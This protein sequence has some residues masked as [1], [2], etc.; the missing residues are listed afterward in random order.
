MRIRINDFLKQIRTRIETRVQAI[1]QA[2][3]DEDGKSFGSSSV[4]WPAS[5]SHRRFTLLFS[6]L[7]RLEDGISDGESGEGCDAV[8]AGGIRQLRDRLL[9]TAKVRE[10]PNVTAAA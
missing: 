9:K 7:D 1:I 10:A 4:T 8:T 3:V 5:K 6:D 2:T